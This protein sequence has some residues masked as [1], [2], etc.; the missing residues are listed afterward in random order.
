[1]IK[2]G[3]DF[4]I[5]PTMGEL[6]QFLK[7]KFPNGE[8]KLGISNEGH[9]IKEA[10]TYFEEATIALRLTSQK[11]MISFDSLG[12]VGVLINS[13][14]LK[15]IK[16]IAKKELGCPLSIGRFKEYRTAENLVCVSVKWWEIRANHG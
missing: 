9:D 12:I 1:M 11:N 2:H 3:K 10:V 14:N 6:Y 13:N 7:K 15:G 4:S 8:F 5:E 16:M